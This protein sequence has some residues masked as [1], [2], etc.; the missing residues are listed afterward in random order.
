MRARSLA[1]TGWVATGCFLGNQRPAL[2]WS[3]QGE[4]RAPL[5]KATKDIGIISL[6]DSCVYQKVPLV[7]S[8]KPFSLIVLDS[9]VIKMQ[10]L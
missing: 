1:A 9:F 3:P 10:Y 6:F 4:A 7:L 5:L 2:A 8:K